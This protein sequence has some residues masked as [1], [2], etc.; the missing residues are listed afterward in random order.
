MLLDAHLIA[1]I[2]LLEA[3]QKIEDYYFAWSRV[4]MHVQILMYSLGGLS[5]LLVIHFVD[6]QINDLLMLIFVLYLWPCPHARIVTQMETMMLSHPSAILL[7]N[8]MAILM[9]EERP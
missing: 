8:F 7:R 4:Y 2:E 3:L 1:R 6:L 9:P 5:L